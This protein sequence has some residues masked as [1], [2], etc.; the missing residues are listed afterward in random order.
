MD[1]YSKQRQKKYDGQTVIAYKNIYQLLKSKPFNGEKVNYSEICSLLTELRNRYI[2]HGTM[3][4]SVSDEMF[5]WVLELILVIAQVFEQDTRV[6]TTESVIFD[7]LAVFAGTLENIEPQSGLLFSYSENGKS[8][9]EY[10]DYYQGSVFAKETK[11]YQLDY[12]GE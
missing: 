12:M 6:L 5:S 2:G 9:F 1:E 10:L 3:A 4:F 11:H 8:N 7:H